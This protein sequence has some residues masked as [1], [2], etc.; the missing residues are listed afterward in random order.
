MFGAF[1]TTTKAQRDCLPP[2]PNPSICGQTLRREEEQKDGPTVL[3]RIA[4]E[5]NQRDSKQHPANNQHQKEEY[6]C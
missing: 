5:M 1:V 2:R 6:T 4:L 3:A